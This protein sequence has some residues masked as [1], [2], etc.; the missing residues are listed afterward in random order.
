MVMAIIVVLGC[1]LL[2]LQYRLWFA[3]GSVIEVHRL[4]E[5]VAAEEQRLERLR[6]RNAA[7]EAEVDD[8]KQGLAAIEARA[9][10]ELG[11]IGRDE[12][13]YLV[14]EPNGAAEDEP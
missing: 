13:F 8:L 10:S 7:L 14:V 3:E 6:E 12:T 9:R 11:M 2:I 4:Q 1:L 5:Q